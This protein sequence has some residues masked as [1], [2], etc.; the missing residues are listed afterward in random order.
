MARSFDFDCRQCPGWT[1]SVQ[2]LLSHQV[3][4]HGP[5]CGA[6]DRH[7]FNEIS[8]R[9]RAVFV[10]AL[11]EIMKML[12]EA[13][14]FCLSYMPLTPKLFKNIY[15]M[16]RRGAL[17]RI[18]QVLEIPDSQISE[19]LTPSEVPS[20][21]SFGYLNIIAFLDGEFDIQITEAEVVDLESLKSV[22]DIIETRS[23]F[24]T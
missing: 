5:L 18:C 9:R 14:A 1:S 13:L 24:S 21:D 16:T 17:E 19:D 15:T 12:A 8:S 11:A 23:G 2:C 4:R 10:F 3:E 6:E 7:P 22:L 20:W